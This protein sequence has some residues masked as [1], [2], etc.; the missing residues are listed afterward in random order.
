MVIRIEL[1]SPRMTIE[2]IAVISNV[3]PGVIEPPKADSRVMK[4]SGMERMMLI[5]LLLE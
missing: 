1:E 5:G 4:K 3:S 2:R